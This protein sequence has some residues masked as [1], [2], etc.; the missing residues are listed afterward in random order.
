[1]IDISEVFHSLFTIYKQKGRINFL[2]EVNHAS[3]VFSR[4]L[5]NYPSLSLSKY[6]AHVLIW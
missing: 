6:D 5:V 4:V 1:M 3:S 2:V